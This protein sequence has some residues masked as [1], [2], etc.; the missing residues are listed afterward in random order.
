MTNRFILPGDIEAMSH[1]VSQNIADA[2]ARLYNLCEL[3]HY[4]LLV[5]ESDVMEYVN[6][7][8]MS[9]IEAIRKVYQEI[10][11]M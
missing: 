2:W 4:L 6:H 11:S 5:A 8:G 10:A 3:K 7:Y 9:E 1:Q